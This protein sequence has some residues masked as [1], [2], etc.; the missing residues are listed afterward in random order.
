MT[1]KISPVLETEFIM[2]KVFPLDK[3]WCVFSVVINIQPFTITTHSLGLV[4]L[5][6]GWK[7]IHF[8]AN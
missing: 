4:F 6:E 8:V 5:S 7:A 2:E 3:M 1:I